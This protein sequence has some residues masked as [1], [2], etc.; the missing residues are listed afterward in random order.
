MNIEIILLKISYIGWGEKKNYK[1]NFYWLLFTF[2]QF[3]GKYSSFV[4]SKLKA[5]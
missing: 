3:I 4:Q 5:N 2:I 1:E